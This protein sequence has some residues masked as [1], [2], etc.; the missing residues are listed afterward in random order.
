MVKIDN[1]PRRRRGGAMGWLIAIVVVLLAAAWL[2]A[3]RHTSTVDSGTQLAN[4]DAITP[5]PKPS[6]GLVHPGS[7]TLG[8]PG[9]DSR[10]NGTPNA[11]RPAPAADSPPVPT[12]AGPPGTGSKPT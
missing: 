6:T 5:G 2:T 8:Q 3:P 4:G 12:P 10:D 11:G 9:T 7:M 1:S